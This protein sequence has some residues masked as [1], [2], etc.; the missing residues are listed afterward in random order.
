MQG[1]PDAHG[2]PADELGACVTGLMMRPTAK[3]P[4]IRETRIAPVAALK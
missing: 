2:H 4:S 3:T 1:H